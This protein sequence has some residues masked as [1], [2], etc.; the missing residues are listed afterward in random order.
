VAVHRDK[1]LTIKPTR[2]TNFFDLFGMKLYL[3]RTVHMPIIRSFSLY[4]QQ[5]YMSANLY[6]LY[7]CCV[8]SEK[9]PMMDRGKGKT[10]PLQAWSCPEGSRK[11]RFADFLKSHRK[12]VSLSALRTGRIYPQEIILVLISVRGWVGPRAIVWSE[13]FTS[14]KYSN[15]IWD[16]ISDLLIWSAVP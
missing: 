1:F 16:R 2:C 4:T 15:D 9:L 13:G 7:H 8:Y 3:F 10:V 5:W 6:D 12:V 11:L 14:K